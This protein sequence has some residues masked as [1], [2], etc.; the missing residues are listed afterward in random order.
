MSG[1]FQIDLDLSANADTMK[2]FIKYLEAIY[3]QKVKQEKEDDE[4]FERECVIRR[5]KEKD[6][7]DK[8]RN[9]KKVK[10]FPPE[11]ESSDSD[12]SIVL[13]TIEEIEAKKVPE[14]IQCECGMD[15]IKKN[16]KRHCSSKTHIKHRLF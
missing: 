2:V 12:E 4:E 11:S 7:R 5:A 10:I 14:K 16:M 6:E 15:I 1:N 9:N 13:K 3:I 8:K